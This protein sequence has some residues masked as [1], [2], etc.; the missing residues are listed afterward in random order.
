MEVCATTR[1]AV[2]SELA[3]SSASYRHGATS[4]IASLCQRPS[5]ALPS[6]P[7]QHGTP[8]SPRSSAIRPDLPLGDSHDHYAASS[9]PTPRECASV[10]LL[11]TYADHEENRQTLEKEGFRLAASDDGGST[12][13]VPRPEVCGVVVARSWWTGIPETER[14]DMLR[15]IHRTLQLRLDEVRHSQS[16]LR[17]RAVPPVTSSVR[18][19][20][21]EW[22]DCVCHDGWRH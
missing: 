15:Q 9:S 14:E 4:R 11:G 2:P 17:R 16:A 6:A 21:P 12:Q 18:Y 20:G 19:S 5:V 8:A 3:C 10:I 13:R 22:D 7:G 1:S